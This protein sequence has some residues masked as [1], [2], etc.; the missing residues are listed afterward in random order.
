MYHY[1]YMCLKTQ[2]QNFK[3]W[4]ILVTQYFKIIF[5]SLMI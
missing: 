1:M 5:T 2:K 4:D 3:G